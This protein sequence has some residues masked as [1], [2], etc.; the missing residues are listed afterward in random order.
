MDKYLIRK[1]CAQKKK[2]FLG[3]IFRNIWGKIPEVT[4]TFA[5]PVLLVREVDGSWRMCID[6]RAFNLNIVK[7]KFPIPV[8][9][10]LLDELNGACMFSKLDLRFGYVQIRMNKEDNPKIAFGTHEGH[11]KF[12]VMPFGLINAPSTFQSL[13]NQVFKPFLRR[14][15]LVFFDDILVYSKFL[16]DHVSHLRDVL[17]VLAKEQLFA[18]KSKC[19]FACGE[20][21][22]LGHL[23]SGE[24]VRTDLR[25]LWQCSSDL[26]QRML[27][28]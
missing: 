26:L 15:V 11:Y 9:D 1:P 25:K 3:K 2:K 7:D 8:I 28:L 4:T 19:V 24:G 27:R 17:E 20:V 12:L 21:E 18:K 5:S 16:V 6:Y 10:E 23:I 22:Y 14:F 13:M